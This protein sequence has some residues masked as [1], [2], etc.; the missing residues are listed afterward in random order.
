[1]GCTWDISAPILVLSKSIM[2]RNSFLYQSHIE[3]YVKFVCKPWCLEAWVQIHCLYMQCIPA[4]Y[5]GPI[6]TPWVRWPALG[7]GKFLWWKEKIMVMPRCINYVTIN[8]DNI[9]TNNTMYSLIIQHV[10][11]AICCPTLSFMLTYF[12][13]GISLPPILILLSSVCHDHRNRHCHC[14]RHCHIATWRTPLPSLDALHCRCQPLPLDA[15]HCRCHSTL[16]FDA[17]H[18]C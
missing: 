17:L 12:K 3:T 14:H 10:Q 4:A 18:R 8:K 11:L 16:P 15:L 9:L 6:Y 2:T 1:M 5:A 13:G 7:L